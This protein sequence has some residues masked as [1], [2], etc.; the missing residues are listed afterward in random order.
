[1]RKITTIAVLFVF[2]AST[3]Y[4][5]IT[6]AE[7]SVV[8]VVYKDWTE[9][10][11]KNAFGNRPEITIR[12]AIEGMN[13][14]GEYIKFKGPLFYNNMETGCYCGKDSTGKQMV[15][16]ADKKSCVYCR[17]YDASAVYYDDANAVNDP[18]AAIKVNGQD[19]GCRCTQKELGTGV[20]SFD[21]VEGSKCVYIDKTKQ[22]DACKAQYGTSGVRVCT[23][24]TTEA[25][26]GNAVAD[27]KNIACCCEPGFKKS[28][29]TTPSGYACV[30]GLGGSLGDAYC[31]QI[32]T[33][34]SLGELVQCSQSITPKE[35]G[36]GYEFATAAAAVRQEFQRT[37]VGKYGTYACCCAKDYVK[38]SSGKCVKEVDDCG[39]MVEGSVV[40]TK[41]DA[42]LNMP[43]LASYKDPIT[44]HSWDPEK[45]KQIAASKLECYC[46]TSTMPFGEK[47]YLERCA[48]VA[49]E[50]DVVFAVLDESSF[51]NLFSKKIFPFA[52]TLTTA[53][54][55]IPFATVEEGP[56]TGGFVL[57][58]GN[59]EVVVSFHNTDTSRS[60]RFMAE[61]V[62]LLASMGAEGG[63]ARMGAK[64][65]GEAGEQ[66]AR[67]VAS[68][69]TPEGLMKATA[70]N[71]EQRFGVKLS[72]E[73]AER[74]V[75]AGTSEGL[76]AG[77]KAGLGDAYE[78]TVKTVGRGLASKAP[79][80]LVTSLTKT[81]VDDLVNGVAKGID[82]LSNP[83]VA[84]VYPAL[85]LGEVT[86]SPTSQRMAIKNALNSFKSNPTELIDKL[87]AASGV[88]S[89]FTAVFEESLGRSG[90]L[91][92]ARGA[93]APTGAAAAAGS[94]AAA[95]GW[96]T[97][98]FTSQTAKTLAFG[99]PSNLLALYGPTIGRRLLFLLQNGWGPLIMIAAS[100]IDV[101]EVKSA[102]GMA[103][104]GEAAKE[105]LKTLGLSLAISFGVGIITGGVGLVPALVGSLVAGVGVGLMEGTETFGDPTTME[106]RFNDH[107]IG[108]EVYNLLITDDSQKCNAVTDNSGLRLLSTKLNVGGNSDFNG[109][110]LREVTLAEMTCTLLNSKSL[111]ATGGYT[112]TE[113][114]P[115]GH[116]NYCTGCHSI[117]LGSNCNSK[118]TKWDEE[119]K[120]R[121]I[122][123][124][125]ALC[126]AQCKTIGNV[127]LGEY[128]GTPSGAVSSAGLGI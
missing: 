120:L 101:S 65:T 113:L 123:V 86:G 37:F 27:G 57:D 50:N 118:S 68:E 111:K 73:A 18:Q 40:H 30:K 49:D 126:C 122:G 31:A 6:L 29:G 36:G 81:G 56:Y 54:V 60:G 24:L 16:S 108:D 102:T 77:L 35:Y 119:N 90:L 4:L 109:W 116:I 67:R 21:H 3:L 82:D 48:E 97:R 2:L 66:V 88:D 61:I 76:E 124:S 96:F 46:R 121:S 17:A 99:S 112:Q 5:P 91:Q 83:V 103:S 8:G 62:T 70:K 34:Q 39:K 13:L 80:E 78:Q 41:L 42:N 10:D 19:I 89:E 84:R 33:Q 94:A 51:Y 127:N 100:E 23:G 25:P 59:N 38:D 104:P 107:S 53:Q 52:R 1:M 28:A 22:E 45:L 47:N 95:S 32:A 26:L 117:D 79:G 71:L 14:V 44:S 125:R 72:G 58:T 98:I 20:K 43:I 63:L 7:E 92:S 85:G 105:G 55:R 11:C 69:L 93:I 9:Q 64:V 15:L 12:S 87:K 106:I 115:G 74:A 75:A 114:M 110:S 128:Y